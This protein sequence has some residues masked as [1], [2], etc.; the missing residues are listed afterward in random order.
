MLFSLAD[1]SQHLAEFVFGRSL[2]EQP[3]PDPEP[4]VGSAGRGPKDAELSPDASVASLFIGDLART[5]NEV[6]RGSPSLA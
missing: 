1:I 6:L 2:S 3:E 4:G 5:I